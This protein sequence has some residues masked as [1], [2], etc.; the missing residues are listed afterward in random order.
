[1][2]RTPEAVV[3]TAPGARDIV[4]AGRFDDPENSSSLPHFQSIGTAAAAL[5]HRL[6]LEHGLTQRHA[7]TIVE[8]A[9]LGGGSA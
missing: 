2:Q 4:S 5:V 9:G 1:M 7:A 8:L 6:A 3:G